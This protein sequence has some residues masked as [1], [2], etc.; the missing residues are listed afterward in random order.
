MQ[1]TINLCTTP[2]QDVEPLIGK[3]RI[4]MI[5]LGVL[6]VCTGALLIFAHVRKN[7]F[8]SEERRLD[9]T[10]IRESSELSEYQ[11]MLEKPEN[12]RLAKRALA[13]NNLFDEKSFSWTLLMKQ[14]EGV[15]PPE[16]QLAT[17]EP[18]REKGGSISIRM[19]VVGPRERVIELIHSLELS[20][21]FSFPHVTAESARRDAQAAQHAAALMPSSI[22]EFDIEAGYDKDLPS[23]SPADGIAPAD[24]HGAPAVP[25]NTAS[26]KP[27]AAQ[28]ATT[29]A[30]I[31]PRR[32]G[33][34]R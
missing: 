8:Q 34:T 19:H 26:S 10:M 16:V 20:N 24:P 3:L 21:A 23:W 13:L 32:P 18:L 11:N 9:S 17:I 22:E 12:V 25:A 33:E 1:I 31:E 6:T 2:Y 7:G 28:L 4:A 27:A 30:P 29:L 14:F 5:S 15:V